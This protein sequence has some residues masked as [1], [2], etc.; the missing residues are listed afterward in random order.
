MKF[1]AKLLKVKQETHDSYTLTF[2]CPERPD[3]KPGQF[4]MIEF[5]RK[6]KIP[7]R[8]YS[9]SSSPER[10][11]I[12]EF[13]IKQMPEGYVSKLLTT[14][15][16]GEEFLLDGP[17]GHFVFE[18]EKMKKIVLLAAGSGIAP[19]RCFC[20]YVLDKNLD[21]QVSLYYS[22]KTEQ[23]IICKND[24][25]E[26]AKKIKGIKLVYCL[27]REERKGYYF[28]RIDSKLIKKIVEENKE[29]YYF[30]CGPPAMVLDTEKILIE[31][32][33]P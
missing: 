24:F 22:N 25:D 13:T 28:G 4:F 8:S 12:L 31:N 9:C 10:K 18:P 32:N 33:V 21:T 17:W 19:F 26:F 7:K 3:F 23:D 16:L 30:I 15:P 29:S 1:K 11:G 6:E 14:A 5:L 20:Q 27:S 2:E